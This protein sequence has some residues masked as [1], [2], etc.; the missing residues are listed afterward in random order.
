[1]NQ[2][3][4]IT[5]VLCAAVMVVFQLF[6]FGPQQ[7]RYDQKVKEYKVAKAKRDKDDAIKAKD[8]AAKAKDGTLKAKDGDPNKT[9]SEDPDQK[10]EDDANAN[11]TPLHNIKVSTKEFEAV[12]SSL[13]ASLRKLT[14]HNIDNN[15]HSGKL[16]VLHTYSPEVVSLALDIDEIPIPLKS[17]E[18]NYKAESGSHVFW[19]DL[20]QGRRIEKI[21]EATENYHFNVKL[22]FINQGSE[23]WDPSYTLNGPAGLMEEYTVRA[24]ELQGVSVKKNSQN[25]F[26]FDNVGVSAVRDAEAHRRDFLAVGDGRTTS[27]KLMY[28]GLNTKYFAS[29]IMPIGDDTH[30]KVHMGRLE[31]LVASAGLT[32]DDAMVE[33]A[34][35]SKKP[36]EQ[37]INQIVAQIISRNFNVNV[38]QTLEHE[39]IFFCGPKSTELVYSKPYVDHGMHKLRD[40]GFGFFATPARVLAALLAFFFGLVGNYGVAILMIT[41]LVRAGMHPLTRKSQMS[42]HKMAKLAPEIK[43]IND[44]Y[45]GKTSQEAKTKKNMETMALYS[46]HGANP[47]A[48]CLP[49]FIQMPIFFALYN[50]LNYTYELRHAEFVLWINDLSQADYLFTLPFQIPFHGTDVFSVLPIVML[51]CYIGNQKLTPKPADPKQAETQK[52]MKFMLPMFAFLFYTVPSGLLLYFI[53]SMAVGMGEQFYIKR[54]LKNVKLT[55]I[56]PKKPGKKGKKK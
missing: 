15:D 5:F 53:T 43:K 47:L 25:A 1:M 56:A 12:F 32:P 45:E 42:I 23:T 37:P 50:V 19:R 29:L 52:I 27:T 51:F 48:G 13:G 8:D 24:E 17:V 34:G 16:S 54:L 33:K 10:I 3:M 2:R 35:K 14:F 20:G 38:G 30:A 41:F 28:I 31:S 21:I 11:I 46:K 44:K 6:I 49:V 7:A 26:I 36:S 40:Y 39:F 55:P 18:W 9:K 22:R 4:I